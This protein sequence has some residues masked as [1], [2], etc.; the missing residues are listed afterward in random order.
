MRCVKA[1]IPAFTSTEADLVPLVE[2]V[3]AYRPVPWV[4]LITGDQAGSDAW[5]KHAVWLVPDRAYLGFL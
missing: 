4:T 3:R 5:S 1:G 2:L